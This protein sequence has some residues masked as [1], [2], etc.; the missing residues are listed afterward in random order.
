MKREVN[1]AEE[2]LRLQNSV[3][4]M[5]GNKDTDQVFPFDERMRYKYVVYHETLGRTDDGQVYSKI[6][7]RQFTFITPKMWDTLYMPPNKKSFFEKQGKSYTILHD[8]ILQASSEGIKI[9]GY[10]IDKTGQSLKDKLRGAKPASQF[11]A[12]KEV[13]NALLSDPPQYVTQ[14]GE[15]FEQINVSDDAIQYDTIDRLGE[16]VVKKGGRPRKEIVDN[17]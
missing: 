3:Q 9:K 8:P 7:T 1:E 10:H 11:S 17:G 4:L 15:T 13:V 14:S 5:Y 6:S 16:V 12:K 2:E